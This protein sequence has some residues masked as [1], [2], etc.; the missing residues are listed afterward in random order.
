MLKNKSLGQI[1][2]SFIPYHVIFKA[3]AVSFWSMKIRQQKLSQV[4]IFIIFLLYSKSSFYFKSYFTRNS[5]IVLNFEVTIYE[6]GQ[7]YLKDCF[8]KLQT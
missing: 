5:E 6:Q 7:G 8:L 3:I 1:L 4:Y 2:N